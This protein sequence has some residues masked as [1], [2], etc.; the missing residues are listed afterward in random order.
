MAGTAPLLS[1][2]LFDDQVR[3]G[4]HSSV[5]MSVGQVA[6]VHHKAGSG[7]G[8]DLGPPA[9]VW[10]AASVKPVDDK[11]GSARFCVSPRVELPG[12]EGWSPQVKI[13][14]IDV[15]KTEPGAALLAEVEST[16]SLPVGAS[17]ELASSGPWCVIRNLDTE[18][19]PSTLYL[20]TQH[21]SGLVRFPAVKSVVSGS[22][23]EKVW[24]CSSP[25]VSGKSA[26]PRQRSRGKQ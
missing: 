19:A 26:E 1:L 23:G 8:A 20:V 16:K 5:C 2:P 11:Q 6:H 14:L 22:S 10:Y 3:D 4:Y 18:P 13:K 25:S 12:G 21:G 17:L 24:T 9:E 7:K 15:S